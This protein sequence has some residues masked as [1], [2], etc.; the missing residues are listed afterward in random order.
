MSCQSTKSA[1]N[2]AQTNPKPSSIH[3]RIFAGF[4]RHDCGELAQCFG[5][6]QILISS[7]WPEIRQHLLQSRC[8]NA[9]PERG[10]TQTTLQVDLGNQ[11]SRCS[12]VIFET[13]DPSRQQIV[14]IILT[15]DDTIAFAPA[16]QIKQIQVDRFFASLILANIRIDIAVDRDVLGKIDVEAVTDCIVDL[17]DRKLRYVSNCDKWDQGGRSVFR[18]SVSHFTRRGKRVEFCLPAFPCKSSSTGK[19]LSEAPDL[20]EYMALENMHNFIQDI[21]AVYEP[22]AKLWII[23]D[24]HVFSDCSE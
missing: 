16:V 9:Y 14:G 12:C 22:G 3:Q 19:V 24:G 20:G 6:F 15:S 13:L 17:F 21:E 2:L 5:P 11:P 4:V 8:Y 10:L 7:K 18:E 1:M 23:S